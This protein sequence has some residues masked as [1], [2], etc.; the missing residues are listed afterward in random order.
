MRGS[1]Q[2][3]HGTNRRFHIKPNSSTVLTQASRKVILHVHNTTPREYNLSKS[4]CQ[5]K[6]QLLIIGT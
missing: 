5:Q 2:P 6:P 4:T 1:R 3:C